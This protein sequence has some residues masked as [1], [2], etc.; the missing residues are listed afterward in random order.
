[1]KHEVPLT[2]KAPHYCI[3][4]SASAGRPGKGWPKSAVAKFWKKPHVFAGMQ[5]ARS[6]LFSLLGHKGDLMLVH[7]RNSFEELN[8]AELCVAQ[9]QLYEFLEPTSSYL[10]VVELGLYESTVRLIAALEEKG[11]A[12]GSPE[13]NKRPSR[14]WSSRGRLWRRGCGRKSRL[15]ATA[16]STHGQE[17][18]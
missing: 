10:S 17:A 13:W 7:F 6:A 4:C 3:R 16:A 12:P 8:Q 1:M 2:L 11:V 15:A 14:R 5:Q 9:L 18:R